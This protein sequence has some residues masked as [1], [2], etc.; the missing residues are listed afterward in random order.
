[1]AEFVG[2][3]RETVTNTLHRLEKEKIISTERAKITIL[4]LKKLQ[5]YASFN[6]KKV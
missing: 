5:K 2:A 6:G 1:V 3:F 4:N